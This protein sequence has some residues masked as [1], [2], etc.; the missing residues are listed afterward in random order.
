MWNK[1]A[2]S[3]KNPERLSSVRNFYDATFIQFLELW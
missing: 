1:T 2:E 3:E